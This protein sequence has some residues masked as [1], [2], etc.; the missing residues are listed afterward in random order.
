MD[1]LI[2]TLIKNTNATLPAKNTFYLDPSTSNQ[3]TDTDSLHKARNGMAASV[4]N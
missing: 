2:M 4:L 3:W 1:D